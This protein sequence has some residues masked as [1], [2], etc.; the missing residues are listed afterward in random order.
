MDYVKDTEPRTSVS[1]AIILLCRVPIIQ[2]ST[3]QKIIAIF[4]KEAKL[5]VAASAT[6]IKRLLKSINNQ[7]AVDMMN[8]Y[9]TGGRTHHM[10]TRQYY[11]M[12]LKEQGI[13]VVTW[14]AGI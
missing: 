1:G 7:A 4:V 14:K 9:S 11:L 3:K 13:M 5:I 12:E 2:R 6:H 10:E 8:N